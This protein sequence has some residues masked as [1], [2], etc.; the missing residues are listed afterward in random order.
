MKHHGPGWRWLLACLLTLCF[1][2][3]LHA[4]VVRLDH[5]PNGPLGSHALYFQEAAGAPLSLAQAREAL[6]RGEFHRDERPIAGFGLG[7]RPVWVY[8]E[9]QNPLEDALSLRL[10]A[11][12][13]WI[14][15]LDV[16]QV[17]GD[18]VLA[19][20]QSGDEAG[21]VDGAGNLIPG[22]GF[23]FPLA[24]P[25]G[26]SEIFIRAQAADPLVMPLSLQ[27][28]GEADRTERDVH[29]G[30][31]LLYGFLL[32]LMAYNTMVFVG[33]RK[34]SYLHYAF[35]LLCFV[36]L[37]LAY[38]G[39]GYAWW[40]S[41]SVRFERYVVL[42]MMA[43][44]GASGF[45]FADHFLD[46][47]NRGRRFRKGLLGTSIAAVTGLVG[48]VLFDWHTAA[49]WLSFS[50]TLFFSIAMALLGI[51]ALRRHHPA[52][53]YFLTAVVCGMGGTM[54][55][56]LSVWGLMPLTPLS[57]HGIEIGV[58]LE[59]TLLALAL[60]NQLRSQ[61][62]ARHLAETLARTDA[63]TGLANRRAFYERAR[64]LWA[65]AKRRQ[66]PL[67]AVMLDVDHFKDFNDRHGH[68]GG[69]R[70]LVLI[71]ELMQRT[72]REGDVSARWGGE[73]FLL[74]LPET[75]LEQGMAFAERL[76]AAVESSA[77]DIGSGRVFLSISLGVAPLAEEDLLDELIAE[78][79]R[80]LYRAKSEG[81]NRV[82]GPV[83]SDS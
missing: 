13:G 55:S 25:A 33:L 76:R 82:A 4:Q 15:R 40:W 29:Y 19:S 59:A 52:A 81:R 34:G 9:L 61:D 57:F 10:I 35:Y 16:V 65:T 12:V 28:I 46:L 21:P 47:R 26:R 73:E 43:A 32:A 53:P 49:V 2:G 70:V 8:L 56:M 77:V 63:L 67:C 75:D 42:V 36:G 66:R 51:W 62:R 38:T 74:M 58:V 17:K 50:F 7:A 80:W 31:G 22:L 23:A 39:H 64:G 1:S 37:N 45:A 41:D 44:F 6:Q 24:V 71:A 60:A 11:G 78:A 30:Y 68:E 54:V 14:D 83:E 20:W 69:D 48:C 3:V 72:C 79:D 5:L 27:L 18:Q